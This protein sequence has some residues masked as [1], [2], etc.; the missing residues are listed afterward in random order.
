MVKTKVRMMT[1]RLMLRSPSLV[2]PYGSVSVPLRD[3]CAE[4]PAGMSRSVPDPVAPSKTPVPPVTL[5]VRTALRSAQFVSPIGAKA[6]I[7]NVLVAAP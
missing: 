1:F 2:A 6:V 4:S 5:I 7:S 3:A